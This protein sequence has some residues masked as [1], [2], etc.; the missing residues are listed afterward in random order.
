VGVLSVAVTAG[1]I[2]AEPRRDLYQKMDALNVDLKAFTEDFY[3]KLCSASLEAVK[4]TLVY[5]AQETQAWVEVTTL[6]IPEH[7]DGD[8]E[9]TELCEWLV[10]NMGPSVPLHF[11]AFHPDFRMVDVPRTPL[12]TLVRAR[13]IARRAGL[14]HVYTGNVHHEDGDTTRCARCEEVVIVRD[15]YHV[16]DY[17]LTES[18][19]C[20]SCGEGLAGRFSDSAESFGRRRLPVTL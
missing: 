11:S 13:E 18:G 1:Y 16:R 4:E 5:L 14:L 15:W 6:L 9:I 12:S 20:P 8:S 17:R 2:H 7:N 3:R 19:A 10:Q